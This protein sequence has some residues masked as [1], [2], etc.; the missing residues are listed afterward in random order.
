MEYD[1]VSE[2]HPQ[3][4]LRDGDIVLRAAKSQAS[5]IAC[6]TGPARFQLFRVHKFLLRHHSIVFADMLDSDR[7]R[8]VEA[9]ETYDGLPLAEMPD[10]ADDLALLLH[11]LYNP[12]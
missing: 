3:L 7:G 6:S 12:A 11:Y 4:Y 8:T 10:S 5:P 1:A 9:G 2:R